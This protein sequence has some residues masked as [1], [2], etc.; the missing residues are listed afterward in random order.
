MICYDFTDIEEVLSRSL[1]VGGKVVRCVHLCPRF[2]QKWEDPQLE[3]RYT[4]CA[5]VIY[6][7]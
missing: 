1:D 3:R 5:F 2:E 6:Y 4:R 7:Y